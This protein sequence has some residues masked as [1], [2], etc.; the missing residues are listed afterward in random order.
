MSRP[1]ARRR[2]GAHHH[3][4]YPRTVPVSGVGIC[5]LNGTVVRQL[6]CKPGP[7]PGAD[8]GE[9]DRREG[10]TRRQ[11]LSRRDRRLPR[12]GHRYPSSPVASRDDDQ[13]R[14][15]GSVHPRCSIGRHGSLPRRVVRIRDRLAGPDVSGGAAGGGAS[16]GMAVRLFLQ[17]TGNAA[18]PGTG[19]DRHGELPCVPGDAGAFRGPCCRGRWLLLNRNARDG[20]VAAHDQN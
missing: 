16:V 2:A 7:M 4:H 3:H 13:G 5:Y 6:A 14:Q 15:L 8:T 19:V 17:I 20:G 12:R 9:C 10:E 18:D 1:Q 11:P